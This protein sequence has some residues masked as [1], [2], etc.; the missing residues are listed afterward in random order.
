MQKRLQEYDNKIALLDAQIKQAVADIN[1][2]QGAREECLF[3]LSQSYEESPGIE[4]IRE[5]LLADKIE[6]IDEPPK[7]VISDT[8]P[9]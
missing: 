6:I 4:K 5:A 2:M 9:E 1:L 8:S 7:P 3:W